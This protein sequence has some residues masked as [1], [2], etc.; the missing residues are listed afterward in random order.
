MNTLRMGAPATVSYTLVIVI[1]TL[2]FFFLPLRVVESHLQH[3]I[4]ICS[5]V[6]HEIMPLA[7]TGPGPGAINNNNSAAYTIKKNGEK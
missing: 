6:D 5:S 7:E 3:N 2:V 4:H 1:M